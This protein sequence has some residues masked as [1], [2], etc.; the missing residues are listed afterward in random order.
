MLEVIYS[1]AVLHLIFLLGATFFIVREKHIDQNKRAI[2]FLMAMMI[3]VLGP[4]YV[5][6]IYL[7]G[8]LKRKTPSD[9]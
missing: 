4:G 2:Q 6:L 3:P 5:V 7:L 9:F 1:L 8:K